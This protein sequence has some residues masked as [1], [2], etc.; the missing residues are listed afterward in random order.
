MEPLL[1]AEEAREERAAKPA[2]LEASILKSCAR[3]LGM[4]Q[5]AA[6]AAAAAPSPAAAAARMRKVLQ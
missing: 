4:Q 6:A 1:A 2:V 3:H 5:P